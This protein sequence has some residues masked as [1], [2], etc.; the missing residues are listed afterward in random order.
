MKGM[1]AESLRVFQE[2]D[3]IRVSDSVGGPSCGLPDTGLKQGHMKIEVTPTLL[4]LGEVEILNEKD[5][6]I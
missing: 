2:T 4:M 1:E 3:S 5:E 6:G